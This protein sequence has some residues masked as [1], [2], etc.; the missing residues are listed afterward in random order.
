MTIFAS[1]EKKY[2]QNKSCSLWRICSRVVSAPGKQKLEGLCPQ[3]DFTAWVRATSLPQ[4][5]KAPHLVSVVP[6]WVT[7]PPDCPC[8]QL[9]PENTS[10]EVWGAPGY[11]GMVRKIT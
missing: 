11:V 10:T 4:G 5:W 6:C 7:S 2:K 9:F 8:P 1:R 3:S